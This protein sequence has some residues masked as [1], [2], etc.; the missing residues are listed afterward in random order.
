MG[1]IYPLNFIPKE[2]YIQ[3]VDELVYKTLLDPEKGIVWRLLDIKQVSVRPLRPRD[4]GLA[5][6]EWSFNIGTAN[7]EVTIIDTT[8][9]DKTIVAIW[10]IFN[11]TLE[12]KV[13]EVLFGT[14]A[15]DIEDVYLEDLYVYESPVG[16]LRRPL[17][18][19]PGTRVVIKA[20][21][22]T[23]P[24]VEQLGFIGVVVEPTGRRIMT[25]D[26]SIQ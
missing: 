20:V 6:D 21:A 1:V 2:Q 13:N 4:L 14:G 24:V 11:K 23:A 5:Q 10:A 9:D 12:P 26:A 22:S 18:F 15:G 17:I 7:T 16:V 3:K 25:A 8:L 19:Q